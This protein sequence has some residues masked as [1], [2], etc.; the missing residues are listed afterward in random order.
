[1][2]KLFIKEL[3]DRFNEFEF[4]ETVS[5]TYAIFEKVNHKYHGLLL[6]HEDNK[7]LLK[8]ESNKKEYLTMREY[9]DLKLLLL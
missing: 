2:N 5:D 4:T 7:I 1:M 3:I 6:L 8:A 9:S